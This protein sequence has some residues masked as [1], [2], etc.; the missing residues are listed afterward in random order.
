MPVVKYEI[1]TTIFQS[2]N[3]SCW[4]AAYCMLFTWKGTPTSSIREKIEKAG[5]DYKDFWANGLPDEKYQYTRAALG[6]A[7]F[8][9]GYF[10]TM[11]EDLEY[12]SDRLKAYGPFWCALSVPSEHAVV[13]CGAD[14]G[15]GK[16]TIT[17]PTRDNSGYAQVEEMSAKDFLTRLG[18]KDV[19]SAAQMFM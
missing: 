2:S 15:R 17:N 3:E 16:I 13:V 4:Y 8:R 9:R 18:S 11:I 6:L 1:D 14:P 12:F 5:L 7:G 19:P 10:R